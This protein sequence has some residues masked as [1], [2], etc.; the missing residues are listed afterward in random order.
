MAVEVNSPTEEHVEK[1]RRL[2]RELLERE[3]DDSG[4]QS[5]AYSGM[6]IPLVRACIVASSEYS[7]LQNKKKNNGLIITAVEENLSVGTRPEKAVDSLVEGF[8]LVVDIFGEDLEGC[9]TLPKYHRLDAFPDSVLPVDAV[10]ESLTIIKETLEAGDRVIILCVDDVAAVV[11]A[12]L[13]YVSQGFD[14]DAAKNFVLSRVGVCDMGRVAPLIGP[15]HLDAA[16]E[17]FK[18]E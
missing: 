9:E 1:V 2:Y 10:T 6:A 11:V 5:Y 15:W 17:L 7:R 8:D 4:L 12:V 3:A 16:T 18:S 13:W 14:E